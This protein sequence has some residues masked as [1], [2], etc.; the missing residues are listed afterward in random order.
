MGFSIIQT[1][2]TQG[3]QVLGVGQDFGFGWHV[4]CQ[5][6]SQYMSQWKSVGIQVWRSVERLNWAYTCM[7]H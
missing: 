1:E 3:E 7:S 4:R 5:L 6:R 2:K